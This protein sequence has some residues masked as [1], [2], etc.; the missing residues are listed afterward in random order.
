[1]CSCLLEIGGPNEK[2]QGWQIKG[3]ESI[4]GEGRR[5]GISDWTAQPLPFKQ[6]CEPR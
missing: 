2:D 5:L 1:M 3:V 6:S 4:G